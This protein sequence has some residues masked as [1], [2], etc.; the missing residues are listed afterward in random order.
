[1]DWVIKITPLALFDLD[2]AAKWYNY[3]KQGLGNE[4]LIEANISIEKLKGNP[5]AFRIVFDPVR[6]FVLKRFPY[7]ILFHV[8]REEIIVIGIVHHKRSSRYLKRRYK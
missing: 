8:E 1:M 2:E 3:Q 4:F 7:K 5:Y 6:R